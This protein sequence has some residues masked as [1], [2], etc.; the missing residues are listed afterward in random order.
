M[1]VIDVKDS[2]FEDILKET[3]NIVV[4]Y[5]ATWCGTCRLF[6]PKFRRMSEE[7]QYKDIKFLDINAEENPIARKMAHVE[8]LPQFAVFKDGKLLESESTSKESRVREL[9]DGLLATA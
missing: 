2:E 5:Y 3:R 1:A 4:K 8:N 7:E 9:I 6:S